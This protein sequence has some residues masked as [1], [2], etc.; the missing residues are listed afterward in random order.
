MNRCVLHTLTVHQGHKYQP[1]KS[2]YANCTLLA[3]MCNKEPNSITVKITVY[4]W[5]TKPLHAVPLL[6]SEA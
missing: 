3:E 6:F 5:R 2:C 1:I 4:L